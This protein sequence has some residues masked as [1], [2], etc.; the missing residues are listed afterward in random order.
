MM[1]QAVVLHRGADYQ[2][3]TREE[4]VIGNPRTSGQRLWIC[5]RSQEPPI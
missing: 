5:W 2:R 4:K 1:M 3:G